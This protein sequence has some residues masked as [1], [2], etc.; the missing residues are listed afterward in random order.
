MI[1]QWECRRFRG[2]YASPV[3]C[4]NCVQTCFAEQPEE[5]AEL[6]AFLVSSGARSMTASTLRMDGGEVK[7]I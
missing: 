2:E 1:G 5:I 6:M 4:G 7:S 3:L